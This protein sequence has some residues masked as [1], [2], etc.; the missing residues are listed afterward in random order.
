MWWIVVI[1]GGGLCSDAADRSR[2]SSVAC[3]AHCDPGVHRPV[4]H[5]PSSALWRAGTV[6]SYVLRASSNMHVTAV[7]HAI[8]RMLSFARV[9][10]SL[11]K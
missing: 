1:P 9:F 5:A 3:R 10:A 4:V 11:I 7:F 6:R 2:T 8:Y